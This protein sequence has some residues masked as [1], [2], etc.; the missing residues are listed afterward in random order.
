MNR[1]KQTVK[2]A[3]V[4]AAMFMAGSLITP[5]PQAGAA[6]IAQYDFE[7]AG[8][9]P[10]TTGSGFTASSV[11]N[12]DT[13]GTA[14]INDTTG[15]NTATPFSSAGGA[16]FNSVSVSTGN[17]ANYGTFDFTIGNG[18][19]SYDITSVSFKLAKSGMDG[20]AYSVTS[21]L[22]GASV[23]ASGTGVNGRGSDGEFTLVTLDVSD[24]AFTGISANSE[25]AFK[26]TLSGSGADQTGKIL[27]DKIDVQG[28]IPEPGSLAL[29]AAGGL[30]MLSRIRD[31]RKLRMQTK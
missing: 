19:F 23:L 20:P 26:I 27:L 17:P 29:M 13:F 1:I 15:D 25:V 8:F 7:G 3:G 2:T 22:T 18:A 4:A 12:A 28:V 14:M 30:L 5:V 6:I 24:P 21:S 9:G 16:T 11:S 31:P 10:T